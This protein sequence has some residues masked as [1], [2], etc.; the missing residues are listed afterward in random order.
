MHPRRLRAIPDVCV[1][2]MKV[3]IS[4]GANMPNI[5][6]KGLRNLQNLD[7]LIE[8]SKLGEFSKENIFNFPLDLLISGKYQPRTAINESDLEELVASI[9]SQGILLP[10]LVRKSHSEKF[11]IIA[12]ERRWRAAK[13]AELKTVPVIIHDITDETALAFA[14]IE[15]LQREGLNPIDE[16]TAFLRLKNEFVMTHEEISKRV[17]RSRSAVSNLIRLLTLDDFVKDMLRTGKIE[18]GHARALLV[19]DEKTQQK[20]THLIINKNLSVRET[21][22]L[23]QQSKL[24]HT[25]QIPHSSKFEE[26]I[27][28]WEHLLRDKFL[29]KVKVTLNSKGEGKIII[30]VHSPDEIE[31]II[32]NIR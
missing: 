7:S 13:I 16:A 14:L 17:G 6:L 24:Q 26:N 4:Q 18:M 32:D 5:E 31:R 10:L 22:K 19:L 8:Q 28:K 20:I 12:G 1:H 15:N 23:V 30:H 3:K 29:S 9:Q 27:I 21:E 2:E 11:E 25:T